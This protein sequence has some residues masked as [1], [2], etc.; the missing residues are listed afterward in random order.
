M[1]YKFVAQLTAPSTLKDSEL[2]FF[3]IYAEKDQGKIFPIF[4]SEVLRSLSEEKPY[5]MAML[6]S[7][8]FNQNLN[9]PIVFKVFRHSLRGNHR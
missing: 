2:Y 8:M 9:I 4:K 3:V 1:T 5:N 6:D 7:R